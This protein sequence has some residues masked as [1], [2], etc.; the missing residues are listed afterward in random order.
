MTCLTRLYSTEPYGKTSDK[1]PMG[2]SYEG[3][4]NSLKQV[5]SRPLLAGNEKN[6]AKPRQHKSPTSLLDQL[7]GRTAL[8]RC[9]A[10]TG[11]VTQQ[12]SQPV[13][14]GSTLPV[15]RTATAFTADLNKYRITFMPS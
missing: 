1:S 15:D 5:L 2:K 10:P 12:A 14:S 8:L 11:Y 6:H 7:L 13:D 4:G 9:R 3:K